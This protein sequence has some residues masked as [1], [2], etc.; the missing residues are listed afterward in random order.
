MNLYDI[1]PTHTFLFKDRIIDEYIIDINSALA[2]DM[3][4]KQQ[5][6]QF[7]M[8]KPIYKPHPSQRVKIIWTLHY[9]NGVMQKLLDS[10]EPVPMFHTDANPDDRQSMIDARVRI[11]GTFGK[12][13][14]LSDVPLIN[15]IRPVDMV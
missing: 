7:L 10:N 5:E 8:R 6:R 13:F 15:P 12:H 9:E 2:V 14:G 4:T 11:V 1:K 3:L